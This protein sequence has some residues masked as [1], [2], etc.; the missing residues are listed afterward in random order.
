MFAVMFRKS[1]QRMLHC[2]DFQ[3]KPSPFGAIYMLLETW[4]TQAT[5]D[6]LNSE[7]GAPRQLRQAQMLGTS[8]EMLKTMSRILARVVPGIIKDLQVH[9]PR[10]TVEQHLHELL[11]SMQFPTPIPAIKVRQKP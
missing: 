11:A 8:Q 10:S 2:A 3:N 5:R 4:T 1:Q 7:T 6:Y 9:V